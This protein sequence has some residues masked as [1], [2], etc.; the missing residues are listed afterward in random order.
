MKTELYNRLVEISSIKSTKIKSNNLK[1]GVNVY[2]VIG[3][4]TSDAN[5]YSSDIEVN[6]AGYVN[7]VK[8]NGILPVHSNESIGL[9]PVGSAVANDI[10]SNMEMSF[11]TNT[12][13]NIDNSSINVQ[14]TILKNSAVLSV[15]YGIMANALNLNPLH[16]RKDVSILGVVGNYDASTEFSGVK[17]EP[18]E[19]SESQIPLL[20]LITEISNL[21]MNLGTNLR[22]YFS[23]LPKLIY[24]SNILMPNITNG[25]NMFSGD[26]SL[27]YISNINMYNDTTISSV[28]LHNMFSYC[29]N[30]VSIDND[31]KFPKEINGARLM[32]VNCINLKYINTPIYFINT[33]TINNA[34]CNCS[35]L[36]DFSNIIF[37]YDNSKCFNT[38]SF[39][40]CTNINLY[41]VHN[42]NWL[43]CSGSHLLKGCTNVTTD[44]I[45]A[46]MPNGVYISN[47]TFENTGIN[48]IP[49]IPFVSSG[50]NSSNLFAQCDG[51]TTINLGTDFFN[52]FPNII[53]LTNLFSYCYNL[54]SVDLDFGNSSVKNVYGLV[55]NCY[56]LKYLNLSGNNLNSIP[57]VATNCNTLTNVNI[58]LN[59][60]GWDR[61]LFYSFSGCSNLVSVN[62]SDYNDN[63]VETGLYSLNFTFDGCRNL[64]NV[65]GLNNMLSNIKSFCNTFTYCSNLVLNGQL[66]I[67]I[68]DMDY[69]YG[70][71]F[72]SCPNVTVNANVYFYYNSVREVQNVYIFRL[73]NVQHIN[74]V[75]NGSIASKSYASWIG[76]FVGS[77]YNLKTLNSSFDINSSSTASFSVCNYC[78]NVT[79]I[80]VDIAFNSIY[81]ISMSNFLNYCPN[82]VNLNINLTSN[83]FIA[84]DFKVKNCPNLSNQS[85]DN[86]L[87]FLVNINY[88]GSNKTL[89]YM[90]FNTYNNTIWETLPNYA[91]FIRAGYS[92]G[93]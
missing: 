75:C 84:S 22:G 64:K 76:P 41:T 16:I 67:N 5:A 34:F 39:Y 24:V 40:G 43:N 37:D 70:C 19:Y 80:N 33:N 63:F 23:S 8:I 68:Y 48:R 69:D 81:N 27:Q 12:V 62:I 9:L 83:N 15:P 74:I 6:T 56:N 1:V 61:N 13:V 90:G 3:D 89:N 32:F 92:V 31:C 44:D 52:N 87:G 65:S 49:N 55:R 10:S 86:I 53:N 2:N 38:L 82:L 21:D 35:N 77:C 20:D 58:S 85:L 59:S 72:Y 46:C 7:A 51:L 30:L 45:E 42:V 14:D 25:S 71:L 17:L 29:S 93:Y 79:D 50:Y 60:A 91:N 47:M 78:F 18:I 66:N 26:Y 73:T 57:R 36:E 4:Y 54:S 88:T 28:P 11:V